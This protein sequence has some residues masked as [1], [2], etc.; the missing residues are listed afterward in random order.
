MSGEEA[1]PGQGVHQLHNCLAAERE[2]ALCQLSITRVLVEFAGRRVNTPGGRRNFIALRRMQR[3]GDALLRVAYSNLT[4]PCIGDRMIGIFRAGIGAVRIKRHSGKT[5]V[6]TET[7][8]LPI[9]VLP[10]EVT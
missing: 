4:D 8:T 6:N 2:M 9:R 5:A 10:R 1:L 7:I 3:L